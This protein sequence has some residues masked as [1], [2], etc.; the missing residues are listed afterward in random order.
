MGRMPLGWSIAI[1][2]LIGLVTWAL[3]TSAGSSDR[4]TGVGTS[5]SGPLHIDN[6]KPAP[7]I[8][9]E[10]ASKVVKLSDYRGQVVLLDFWATY[11]APCRQSMPFVQRMYERYKARGFTV[12]GVA[13]RETPDGVK[14]IPEFA[15]SIGVTYPIGPLRVEKE[16]EPYDTGGTPFMA[17][18]DR[19]GR[20]CWQSKG[21]G[22]PM[23]P[24]LEDE[25]KAVL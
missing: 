3:V 9:I 25:I 2:L 5:I 11:C 13:V 19:Q 1:M 20:M 24:V 23:E 15:K 22:P 8:S 7:D 6:P 12:I 18:I 10:S 4:G 14:Q 17:L 21:F 16:Y